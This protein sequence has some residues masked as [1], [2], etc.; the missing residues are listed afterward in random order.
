MACIQETKLE[1]CETQDWN[2]VGRGLLE[3]FLAVNANKR[4]GGVIVTWK[5]AVFTKVDAKMGQF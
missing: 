4:S 5:V 1:P 2:M 3:D